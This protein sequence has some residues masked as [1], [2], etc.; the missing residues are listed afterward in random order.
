M[1]KKS[2]IKAL[3]ETAIPGAI[4]QVGGDDGVHFDATVVSDVFTGLS[5][6]KQ[7]QR[8]YQA[9]QH[10]LSDG[11]LHALALKTYTPAEWEN[12]GV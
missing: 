1:L 8:V 6:V 5:R 9:V 10:L 12:K 2:E 4:V 3:I 7:Q 11:T